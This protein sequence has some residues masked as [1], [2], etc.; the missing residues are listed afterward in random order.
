MTKYNFSSF[1]QICAIFAEISVIEI[2][3]TSIDY[4]TV[5]SPRYAFELRLMRFK[6]LSFGFSREKVN[7]SSDLNTEIIFY[8]RLII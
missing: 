4:C 6:D 3:V 7:G 1:D 8:K 2:F 5:N